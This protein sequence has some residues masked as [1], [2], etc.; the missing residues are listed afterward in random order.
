MQKNRRKKSA[1]QQNTLD[2]MRTQLKQIE[3]NNDYN[4]NEKKVHH[5]TNGHT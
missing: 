3:L 2:Y 1:K 4:K 5:L